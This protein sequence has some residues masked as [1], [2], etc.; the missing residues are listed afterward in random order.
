MNAFDEILGAINV[1]VTKKMKDV[2][3][4]DFCTVI[5]IENKKCTVIYNGSQYI[6]PY[7]GNI[8]VINNKYPIFLPNGNLSQGFIIG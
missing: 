7:Y 6:L 5:E 4:F 2:S 1:L 3:F 8:P